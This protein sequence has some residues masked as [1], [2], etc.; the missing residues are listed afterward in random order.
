MKTPLLRPS[1]I[2]IPI[3]TSAL[4]SA[5]GAGIDYEVTEVKDYK[6]YVH[7]EDE[8]IRE[9]LVSLMADFNRESCAPIMS[10]VASPDEANSTITVTRDLEK[11]DGKVGW[12]RWQRLTVQDKPDNIVNGRG[13][14][15]HSYGMDLEFDRDYFLTRIDLGDAARRH[16]LFKLFSHESGHGLQM[17]HDNDP[18]SLMY[19]DI[20]GEKDMNSF[21]VR[22]RSYIAGS[23]HPTS[24]KSAQCPS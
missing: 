11:R 18:R 3:V 1:S 22:V 7:S 4:L 14:I 8:A 13:T 2:C 24:A 15:L 16:E 23:E 10:M 5:C 12:G 21:F 9:E 17:G 20:G 6:F 19:G